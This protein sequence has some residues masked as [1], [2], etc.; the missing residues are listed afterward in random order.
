V[1]KPLPQLL[2]PLRRAVRGGLPIPPTALIGREQEVHAVS[3]LLQRQDVHLVTI[4]GTAGVGKTRLALQVATELP[5]EFADRVQFVQLAPVTDAE[6][7][8]PTIAHELGLPEAGGGSVLDRLISSL[9]V[10]RVLLVLDNFEQVLLAAIH[11]ATLLES[12]PQ[13]TLLVTSREILHLRA[14]QQY[15][16]LPLALPHLDQLPDLESL[17][18]SAAV[19]LFI[20]RVQSIKPEF[21]LTKGNARTIAEI[22]HRLDALPLAI[23][24]AAA[25]IKILSPQALL[26]RLEH[27]LQVLTGGALDLPERQRTLRNTIVW[28]Y[29][30]LDPQEQ[31]VFRSLAAYI[32]G[33]SVESVEVLCGARESESGGNPEPILDIIVSLIDKSLLQQT[34][35]ETEE[36]R[37][38]MLETIREFGLECLHDT[39]ELEECREA[40]ALYFLGLAEKAEPL[41]KGAQQVEWLHRLEAEQGNIRAALGWLIEHRVADLALRFTSSLWRFWFMRGYFGEGRQWLQASLELIPR[42]EESSMRAKALCG[43]GWINSFVGDIDA[44]RSALEESVAIFRELGDKAGQAEAQSELAE[45]VYLRDDVAAAR[46]LFEDC[47]ELAREANEPWILSM[48]LRTLGPFI[49]EHDPANSERAVSLLEESMSLS[50]ELGDKVGLMR[51]LERSLL[52]ATWQG[53]VERAA[54]LAKENLSLVYELDNRPDSLEILNHVA[55]ATLFQGE[56]ARAEALLYECIALA[57]EELAETTHGKHHIA[58]ALL[59]L[60][61]ISLHRG[62]VEQAATMLV[63]SLSLLRDVSNDEDMA[64]ALASLGE[65]RRR[66]G[67]LA[68]ARQFCSE[69]LV[70]SRAREYRAGVGRNL[71]GLARI[72]IDENR[73]KQA[74]RL[75]ASASLWLDP[76]TKLDPFERQEYEQ[77]LESLRRQLDRGAFAAAWM[78]GQVFTLDQVLALPEAAVA[79]ESTRSALYSHDLTERELEVLHLLA[80]GLTNARIAEQL[81]ISPYTVNNHVRSILSKLGVS[82]RSAAT[83]YAVEHHLL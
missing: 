83:R 53:D 7:V 63:R 24:L 71:M 33:A 37:L 1:Q 81:I 41:L 68:Q 29:D 43:L 77:A 22:C 38:R 78:Q 67:D 32:G 39:G 25:R 40:H 62:E 34:E 56:A 55:R 23:E 57:Q 51:A 9:H 15:T 36:P 76:G 74:V 44:A 45:G 60:G 47:L 20:Q 79:V 70:L 35:Q 30:L 2:T 82:S 6:L 12:C 58:R 11:L 49:Y 73:L 26:A 14:E 31:R 19:T 48:L 61:E 16:L 64:L 21:V 13:L 80:E 27:R 75:Y 69:G 4:T 18:Q 52:I 72:A 42:S 46:R 17:R 54:L 59:T 5:D 10:Q 66:Q 65:A 50:R 28:S 3:E 8:L